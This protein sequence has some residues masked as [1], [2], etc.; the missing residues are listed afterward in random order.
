[1]YRPTSDPSFV[2]ILIPDRA[3]RNERLDR[4]AAGEILGTPRRPTTIAM[5]RLAPPTMTVIPT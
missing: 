4:E 5:R 3:G 1:M 2:D